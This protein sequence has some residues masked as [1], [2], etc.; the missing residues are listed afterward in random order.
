MQCKIIQAIAVIVATFFVLMVSPVSAAPVD[1]QVKGVSQNGD[2]IEAM[3]D[4]QRKA[5][6]RMLSCM[7]A[8]DDNPQSLY[9]QILSGYVSYSK[10]PVIIR[11]Q[12][13]G[14]KLYLLSKVTV[15][16]DKLRERLK[17]EVAQK[18][19]QRYD[20]VAFVVRIQG[21]PENE[22]QARQNSLQKVFSTTFKN[23]GLDTAVIDGAT[24]LMAVAPRGTYDDFVNQV[25]YNGPKDL[26]QR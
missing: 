3:H 18:Q 5:V 10:K 6:Q 4:A 7:I 11:K 21:V 12:M 23:I 25:K 17:S 16:S 9:Q 13:V 14:G 26:D 1:V 24:D 8:A 19:R 20:N 15:D 22:R 2:V